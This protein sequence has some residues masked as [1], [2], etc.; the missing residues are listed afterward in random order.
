MHPRS[1]QERL[2]RHMFREMRRP[3]PTLLSL[4]LVAAGLLLSILL[5]KACQQIYLPAQKPIGRQWLL[6][7]LQC[8]LHQIDSAFLPLE[9]QSVGVLRVCNG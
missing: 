8:I 3:T 2:S 4:V 6:G 1:F 7:P 9:L 5:R